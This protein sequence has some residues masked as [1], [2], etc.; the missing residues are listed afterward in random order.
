MLG[1]GAESTEAG[2]AG[3]VRL[4]EQQLLREADEL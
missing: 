3:E 4:S 2:Q 1:A